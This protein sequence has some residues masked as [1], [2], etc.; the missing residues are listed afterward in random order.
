MIVVLGV[1]ICYCLD[2]G[3]TMKEVFLI[4]QKETNVT[5]KKKSLHFIN[6]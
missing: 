1:L 4:E 3:G 5:G 6:L 2:A